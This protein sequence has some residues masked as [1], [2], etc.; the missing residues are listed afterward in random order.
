MSSTLALQLP[1]SRRATFNRRR[2]R[3]YTRTLAEIER[4]LDQQLLSRDEYPEFSINIH[5]YWA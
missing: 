4:T 2:L 5:K 1:T 3:L